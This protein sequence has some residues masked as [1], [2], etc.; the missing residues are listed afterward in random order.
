MVQGAMATDYKSLVEERNKMRHVMDTGR[1]GSVY[2]IQATAKYH[3]I[4]SQIK[5]KFRKEYYKNK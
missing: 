5:T 4:V 3:Q 2:H 1:K